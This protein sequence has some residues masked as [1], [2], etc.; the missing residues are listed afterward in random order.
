MKLLI[1]TQKVDSTDPILGF[2]H[3]W[4]KEFAT[5][6]EKIIVVC[7]QKGL[8]DLPP[9]VQ[10]LSLG[11]EE[12]TSRYSYI[13]KLFSYSWK[14]R[15]EYDAVF[16]H[17]NPIYLVV[18]GWLWM[19]LGKRRFL[20]YTH[21]HVDLKLEIAV[22]FAQAIFTAS[23]E[24]FQLETKKVH[25]VGHGIDTE[26]FKPFGHASHKEYFTITSAGRISSIKNYDVMLETLLVLQKEG[27]NIGLEIIGAPVTDADKSYF[28]HLK[29]IVIEKNIHHV[30]FVGTIPNNMIGQKIAVADL[31][32]NMSETGSMDK[33]VLEAM[34]CEVP[35]LTSNVAFKDIL[36]PY[37][38]FIKKERG[39]IVNRIRMMYDNQVETEA[40][41][42][43][44]RE[45]VIKEHNLTR[46]INILISKMK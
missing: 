40:I 7:L 10:V 19:V 39:E 41:A 8:H 6:Y 11:K 43:N 24:S 37:N 4:I 14:Y 18:A 22:F 13:R 3:N 23:R 38:L 5:H 17:M 32:I 16:V 9:N 33:A 36:A 44:L 46:L 25:V 31:F 2:F 1:V 45:I 29:K 15:K 12:G 20:W 34:A 35:V 21:K 28:E 27:K 26:L 30:R 42:R